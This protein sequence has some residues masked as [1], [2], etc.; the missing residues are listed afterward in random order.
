MHLLRSLV[1]DYTSTK[2]SWQRLTVFLRS[3]DRL[4]AGHDGLAVGVTRRHECFTEHALSTAAH[5]HRVGIWMKL[6]TGFIYGQRRIGGVIPATPKAPSVLG[7]IQRLACQN[8]PCTD[9][10]PCQ[11]AGRLVGYSKAF[12][13]SSKTLSLNPDA[14][15]QV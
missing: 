5:L 6:R 9:L 15:K 14:G 13:R 12:L 11:S 3:T 1:G 2:V 8:M 4:H 7:T 10:V